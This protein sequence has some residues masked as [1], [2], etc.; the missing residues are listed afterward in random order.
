MKIHKKFFVN[1][2]FGYNIQNSDWYS[3]GATTHT[4]PKLEWAPLN[5]LITT[6]C[7][8]NYEQGTSKHE[9]L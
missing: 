8:V 9:F 4:K 5:F 6:V 2:F 7:I 3:K 1:N